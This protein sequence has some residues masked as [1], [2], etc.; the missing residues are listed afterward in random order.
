[1]KSKILLIHGWNYTN[2]TSQGCTN[3][4]ENRSKFVNSLSEHFEV[5]QFNLPGFCGENDPKIA[6]VLDD[7]VTYVGQKIKQEKP[8]YILGYSFGGAIA[9]RWKKI[10]GDTKIKT[11]LVSPAIIRKYEKKNFGMIQKIFKSILPTMIISIF[12]DIY[13]TRFIKNPYYTKASDVMRK[14]YR[15]IV[16]VDL[17]NDLVSLSDS[18]SLIY[19]ENDT[20]TPPTLL[21]SVLGE[22]SVVQDVRIILGGGHDIANTHTE[23]LVSEI[24]KIKERRDEDKHKSF[25]TNL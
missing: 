7:F 24:L 25:E 17:R 16:A 9:L 13:L 10:S 11:I 20:A 4:W 21:K 14:T 2:Y 23:Q 1:M 8:D 15:N 18:V 5:I 3:A 22:C 6:W 12:R 19:G